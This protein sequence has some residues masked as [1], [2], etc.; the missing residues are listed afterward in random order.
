MYC[1]RAYSRR[2]LERYL[3]LVRVIAEHV[4]GAIER[5]WSRGQSFFRVRRVDRRFIT[6]NIFIL[7]SVA[8]HCLY[9]Q[10]EG[11]V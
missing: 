1:T 8:I 9:Q 10:S 2:V 6:I 3:T 7:R 5:K 4:R 11:D